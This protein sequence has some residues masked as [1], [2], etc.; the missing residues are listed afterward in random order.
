MPREIVR[1]RYLPAKNSFN[2]DNGDFRRSAVSN[3]PEIQ[4]KKEEAVKQDAC[5]S[6]T[7]FSFLDIPLWGE[8]QPVMQGKENNCS[9]YP[10]IRM[11]ATDPMTVQRMDK[12]YEKENTK[13]EKYKQGKT[14]GGHKGEGALPVAMQED[15]K[16]REWYHRMKQNKPGE[17]AKL[18]NYSG[19]I[20]AD[21]NMSGRQG[22]ALTNYYYTNV[23]P[24]PKVSKEDSSSEEENLS[25]STEET[26]YYE[27]IK[28]QVENALVKNADKLTKAVKKRLDDLIQNYPKDSRLLD[29]LQ[30]LG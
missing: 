24:K 6:R 20:S 17:L 2:R 12:N 26:D 23:S 7:Y 13:R 28:K 19:S 22:K 5:E 11:S 14:R 29:L 18:I 1:Q 27:D 21:F 30:Q 16:F 9:G 25:S 15:G 8:T 10:S 4:G 3:V